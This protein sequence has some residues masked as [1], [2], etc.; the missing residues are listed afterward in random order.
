MLKRNQ[1]PLGL[2][3]LVF[4][5]AMA[6]AQTP[7]TSD[8]EGLSEI[9]VTARGIRGSVIADQEIKRNASSVV[10]AVT[11]EDLG[12]FS[13]QNIADSIQ[14]IPG[15]QIER[16]D[17][18]N[19]G[20]RASI[21]GLGSN[22]VQTTLNGRTVLSYGN[23][24]I[25]DLRAFNLDVL[26]SEVVSGIK[27]Y[28]TP[29]AELIES[30]LAGEIDFQ[31][32]RPLD[33]KTYIPG[34]N[35]FG[36]VTA[37]ADNDSLT[38]RTSERYSG[39]IG[40]KLFDGTLGVYAGGITA[41]TPVRQDEY[42]INQGYGTINVRD[43]VGGPV[44]TLDN[45]LL[46]TS[47][48]LSND[49]GTTQHHSV[50]AGAQW[51]PNSQ[52][53]VNTDFLYTQLNRRQERDDVIY[54]FSPGAFSG[55]FNPGSYTVRNGAL[56]QFNQAGEDYTGVP[57]G[58]QNIGF[59]L[60]NLT[61][62]NLAYNYE[63][64]LN[65]AW[66]NEVWT[67]DLDYSYSF[68]QLRQDLVIPTDGGYPLA[69]DVTFN[70][71]GK[72]PSVNVGST[73]IYPTNNYDSVP[74]W[75][76]RQYQNESDQ[77]GV[78]LDFSRHFGDNTTLKFGSRWTSTNVDVRNTQAVLIGQSL[79]G[80]DITAAQEAAM[81]AAQVT[82]RTITLF[83]GYNVGTQTFPLLQRIP[84]NPIYNNIIGLSTF[85]MG[86][87]GGSFATATD[88]NG[89]N[90]FTL[91][92][93]ANYFVNERT[94]A[95]YTQADNS[96]EIAG[97]KYDANVGVR[98][99]NVKE[100]G[101]GYSSVTSVLPITGQI[102][103]NATATVTDNEN[104]WELLPAANL[105]IHINPKLS[106]RLGVSKVM[107]LP[108]Y[109]QLAPSN[110]LTVIS[111]VDAQG[112]P[113][114]GYDPSQ[115]GVGSA[116]NTHLRPLTAWQYDSTLEFYPLAYGAYYTS[117][118][119]KDVKNFPLAVQTVGA[120]VPGQAGLFD[121]FQAGNFTGGKVYG[122]EFGFS[123]IMGFLPSPYDGFGV[124]ANY[125]YVKS[126]FD[127]SNDA[128]SEGSLSQGFPG[129]SLNNFNSTVFYEKY[130][131]GVRLS[132]VYRSDYLALL[133]QPGLG[134]ASEPTSTR[135]FGTLDGSVS[136]KIIQNLEVTL[137]ALNIT[138]ANRYD[139]TNSPEVTR[140]F[141]TRPRIVSLSLRGTF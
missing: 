34:T 14:R 97:Y 128:V 93:S 44:T 5:S 41:N 133:A 114:K 42:T 31:T 137:A 89:E 4:A 53:D 107:S 58:K 25:S 111:P 18:G 1:M 106:L 126:E 60:I 92:P 26:P 84:N 117:L 83:P 132:Y 11:T 120:T 27:V 12:K 48:T 100:F 99:V 102:I 17:S 24:G 40:A 76:R 56:V 6:Y 138:E 80:S 129:S 95:F 13:D 37:R 90:G 140:A 68:S 104:Y 67:A 81:G 32:L 141:F 136:Y 77:N 74:I 19:N 66:H 61:Y 103:K 52:F 59:Q 88:R 33:V 96:G 101:Q 134:R 118:F 8:P 94:L 23:E 36:T 71:L 75:I 112:N 109:D 123:Q 46:P 20:D 78:R 55:V 15:V 50:V 35:Y 86:T 38:N 119:Y 10:E 39:I 21:R 127:R 3:L 122:A 73:D 51:K 131:L 70:A 45:I 91:N 125:T 72:I 49:A 113:A 16:N 130:G 115:H 135:G 2:I 82:G 124:E 108:D 9:V 64:G 43:T 110:T 85:G 29:T 63:A 7:G 54:N 98:G 69:P 87:L 105:N 22:Y 62:D 79:G 47:P 139:Y 121:L 65:V 57:P 116:G 30:G 28:K